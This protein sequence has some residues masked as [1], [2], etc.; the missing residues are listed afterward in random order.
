MITKQNVLAL[1]GVGALCLASTQ[2]MSA[3]KPKPPH[4]APRF[5][6]HYEWRTGTVA[7]P[8]QYHYSI[9]LGSGQRGSMT[10]SPGVSGGEP[11]VWA[12]SFPVSARA[13]DRLRATMRA[14]GVFTR[15]WNEAGMRERPIGGGSENMAVQA[16]GRTFSIPSFVSDLKAQADAAAVY[17]TIN[18]LV[19]ARVRARLEAQ[20]ERYT[21]QQL[22]R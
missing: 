20:R 22:A 12:Q 13:L 21:R 9:A 19:P 15:A 17:A 7:P 8:Y 18:A 10:M 2:S 1:L 16:N 6:V 5:S 4:R 3:A 14:R 11:P